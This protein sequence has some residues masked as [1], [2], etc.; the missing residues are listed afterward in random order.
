MALFISTF[1]NKVDRKGRVSV[2]ATFRA[3]LAQQSFSGIY[4][5]RSLTNEALE[6]CG[7][8]H[9][10]M[11]SESL[12]QLDPFSVEYDDLSTQIFGLSSQ[13]PFDGE[14][15]VILPQELLSTVG[16]TDAV[17]F[18]G[19]GRTF[20]LWEPEAFRI[21]SEEARRR[22]LQNRPSLLLRPGHTP[23]EGEK[24]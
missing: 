5:Y 16:I 12:A 11:L 13:L 10:D 7:S 18:V 9:M 15:R 1:I 20:Q 2:P 3:A 19:K 21:A 24:S 23:N 4:V 22:T 6:G 8:D 14:G 17:A